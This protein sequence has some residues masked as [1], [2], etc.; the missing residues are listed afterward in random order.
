MYQKI[1]FGKLLVA[2][3]I[4]NIVNIVAFL[5]C[6][7]FVKHVLE[8]QVQYKLIIF[9]RGWLSSLSLLCLF[10]VCPKFRQ[11]HMSKLV[12]DMM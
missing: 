2:S 12:S 1:L 3:K 10:A 7:R 8:L 5:H 4:L 6:Y 9:K 11:C